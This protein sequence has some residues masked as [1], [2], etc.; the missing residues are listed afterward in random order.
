MAEIEPLE[1]AV[2]AKKRHREDH[3]GPIGIIQRRIIDGIVA[4]DDLR[5]GDHREVETI[6]GFHIGNMLGEPLHL[7][8]QQMV[9][10]DLGLE[11]PG[12][13]AGA[14][15]IGDQIV[16][17][18]DRRLRGIGDRIDL[19]GV[20]RCRHDI[21]FRDIHIAAQ[22]IVQLLNGG[23]GVGA[24]I[25]G[26]PVD[27]LDAG[28]PAHGAKVLVDI[29]ELL[30]RGGGGKLGAGMRFNPETLLRR[31]QVRLFLEENRRRGGSSE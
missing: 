27:A 28:Q 16:E 20:K 12:D 5:A 15:I 4:G 24:E 7:M 26:V 23:V 29:S 3:A 9:F 2:G 18:Q 25:G 6:R 22:V 10:V 31:M 13:V 1:I 11:T 8:V 30:L 19:V 17:H 14:S 21:D